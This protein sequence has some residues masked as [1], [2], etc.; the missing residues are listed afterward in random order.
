M[1]RVLICEDNPVTAKLFDA[2]LRKFG[3]E[4]T[5]LPDADDI[6]AE[7]VARRPDL[8]LMDL[9]LPGIGGRE[10]IA[11]L[12]G[13]ARTAAVRIVLHSANANVVEIAEELGVASVGKPFDLASF[14]RVVLA[15]VGYDDDDAAAA[16]AANG[17]HPS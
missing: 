7:V 12:R 10:A 5:I 13:D 8:V 3:L 17:P 9:R 2:A 14:R 11:A 15:A 16:V 4:L 1:K 6:V